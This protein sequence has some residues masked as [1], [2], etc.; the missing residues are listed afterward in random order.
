MQLSCA[1]PLTC[2]CVPA[3]PQNGASQEPGLVLVQDHIPK[4]KVRQTLASKLPDLTS[5]PQA[6]NGAQGDFIGQRLGLV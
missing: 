3:A 1:H 2:P 5:I 6:A 4:V